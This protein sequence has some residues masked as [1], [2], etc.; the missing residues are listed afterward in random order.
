MDAG[1]LKLNILVHH[2]RKTYWAYCPEFDLAATGNTAE[3]ARQA[4]LTLIDNYLEQAMHRP[5]DLGP[6]PMN[7]TDWDD[8]LISGGLDKNR[9]LN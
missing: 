7:D 1:Q 4:V 5:G 2:A 6:R 8:E 3:E 9:T